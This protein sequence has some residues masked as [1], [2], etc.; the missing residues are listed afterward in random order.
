MS[1][2]ADCRDKPRDELRRT[3]NAGFALLAETDGALM[4]TQRYLLI[5]AAQSDMELVA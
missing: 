4:H 3:E 5:I 2:R 1:I